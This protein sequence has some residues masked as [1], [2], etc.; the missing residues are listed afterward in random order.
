M[1]NYIKMNGRKSPMMIKDDF[2]APALCPRQ[3]VDKYWPR[4][5]YPLSG[6]SARDLFSGVQDTMRNDGRKLR[7]AFKISK[8]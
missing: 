6:T 5:S 4:D 8:V 2:S 3:A 1:A 7:G